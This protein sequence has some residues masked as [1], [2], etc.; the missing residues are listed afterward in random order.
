[1]VANFD[2]LLMSPTDYLAWEAEQSVRHEYFHGAAYA[3]VGGTLAHN[4]I[5]LNIASW[6]RGQLRG[7]GCHTYMADAKVQINAAGPYFYPDGVVTCDQR[8]RQATS[9]IS[10]PKLIIEVLSPSTAGFDRGDK[11]KAYRRL[12]SLQEYLLIDATQVSVDRYARNPLNQWVLTSYPAV[13]PDPEA[14]WGAI[15]IH[16]ESLDLTA[17]LGMIYEEVQFL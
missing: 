7:T 15:A 2:R 13:D 8:D 3:M 1:M 5:A 11:F 9:L 4:A 16:L 14:D 10:H 6:L 12:P 17:S